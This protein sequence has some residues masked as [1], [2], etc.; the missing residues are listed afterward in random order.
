MKAILEFELLKDAN[1][2]STLC[3]YICPLH[4]KIEHKSPAINFDIDM[5]V[6]ERDIIKE[7]FMLN[8]DR[9]PF[10]PLKIIPDDGC[11]KCGGEM[12]EGEAEIENH[13]PTAPVQDDSGQGSYCH[14]CRIFVFEKE[15][16]ND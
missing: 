3:C 11:P 16:N 15:A 14:A 6:F 9:P 7:D 12:E 13:Y 4:I 8:P 5:C 1:D 10:C 2:I